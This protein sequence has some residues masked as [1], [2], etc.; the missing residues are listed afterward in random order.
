MKRQ[1]VI[2]SNLQSIGYDESR[3]VLEIEFKN[4][5]IYQY[6]GVPASEYK[7]LMDADSH[8]QYL[9]ANIKDVYQY[10]KIW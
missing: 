3:R 5:T 6:H 7:K 1:A 2:S 9:H 4:N 8:G 10:Q